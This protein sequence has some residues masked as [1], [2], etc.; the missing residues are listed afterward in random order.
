[1]LG[2]WVSQTPFIPDADLFLTL[3]SAWRRRSRTL[4]GM[5]LAA[6]V[7]LLSMILLERYA[8]LMLNNSALPESLLANK[9]LIAFLL[10]Q[11]KCHW[12]FVY[13]VF[14]LLFCPGTSMVDQYSNLSILHWRSIAHCSYKHNCLG[15]FCSS[16]DLFISCT[17]EIWSYFRRISENITI[18][19]FDLVKNQ[20]AVKFLFH[21]Y[22]VMNS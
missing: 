21:C 18:Y 9:W 16:L 11:Y 12:L 19:M 6:L 3:A 20:F 17:W 1:M 14:D 4:S 13:W 10:K 2:C 15:Y 22:H 7:S 8:M 5:L